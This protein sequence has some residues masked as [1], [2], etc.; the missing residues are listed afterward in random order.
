MA[1]RESRALINDGLGT[2]A[3]VKVF[4]FSFSLSAQPKIVTPEP[5][6]IQDSDPPEKFQPEIAQ[7]QEIFDGK[8]FLAFAAKDKG[9]GI[10]RY[11]V[12]EYRQKSFFSSPPGKLPL[13][14]IFWLTKN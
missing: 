10:A 2:P 1:I 9:S 6:K 8:N 11:E 14:R 12:R 7:G 4:D 13:A 3:S 5:V